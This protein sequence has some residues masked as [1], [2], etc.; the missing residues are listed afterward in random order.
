MVDNG[1]RLS[2]EEWE[3]VVVVFVQGQACVAVQGMDV[4]LLC[5]TCWTR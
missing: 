3:R 1:K 4:S 2:A 5:H